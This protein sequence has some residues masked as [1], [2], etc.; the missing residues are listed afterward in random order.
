MG[1]DCEVDSKNRGR[2]SKVV[3]LSEKSRCAMSACEDGGGY[4][5]VGL[6]DK[7]PPG[8]TLLSGC[9]KFERGDLVGLFVRIHYV[10]KDDNGGSDD[11]H[12]WHAGKVK[13]F[14][15]GG[16]GGGGDSDDPAQDI[17]TVEW[18]ESRQID[19]MGPGAERSRDSQGSQ[20]SQGG[21]QD[22]VPVFPIGW[23]VLT[24]SHVARRVAEQQSTTPVVW[25]APWPTDG[26]QNECM[27]KILVELKDEADLGK[28]KPLG[29]KEVYKKKIAN[30]TP[31]QL[32]KITS[33]Y[34]S[35]PEGVQTR[36]CKEAKASSLNFVP[37][38][39]PPVRN[40]TSTSS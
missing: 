9:S 31:H 18:L 40:P 20:G 38:K 22:A 1:D 15:P 14:I 21:S 5:V 24:S 34:N 19:L 13:N 23:A 25:S 12:A 35:L 4:T 2:N 32:N 33:F 30:Y 10:T 26:I 16:G 8:M 36:V 11:V 29:N 27:R 28:L 7:A 3:S 6:I 17:Y 39:A 37:P